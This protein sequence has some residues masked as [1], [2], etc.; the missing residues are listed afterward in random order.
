[1]EEISIKKLEAKDAQLLSSVALKAYSDHYLNLWHD[2]GKWYT[3]KYFSVDR[4]RTELNDANAVFYLAY[5]SNIPVGFLKLNISAPL[6]GK[7][8][9]T[10]LELE[11]IYLNKEA[12]GKGVGRKLVE[13]AFVVA[14]QNNKDLVWLK[15]MDTSHSSIA[16]YKKMGFE[17][18]GTYLLRHSLMKENLR[19]MVIMIKKQL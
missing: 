12:T 8:D 16:F 9:K 17:I 11:R 6:Q 7:E 13:L 2:E 10:P 3:D 15:A 19:G 5:Y 18:F 14:K 4:L 1:M